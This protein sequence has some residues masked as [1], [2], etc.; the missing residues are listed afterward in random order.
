MF[1]CKVTADIGRVPTPIQPA[2][3]AVQKPMLLSQIRQR[4]KP[5]MPRPAGSKAMQG[6]NEGIL[7]LGIIILGSDN[8]VV[9]GVLPLRIDDRLGLGGFRFLLVS[10]VGGKHKTENQ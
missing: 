6:Q 3:K 5:R 4:E 7:L 10:R 1:V 2:G 8:L 9:A